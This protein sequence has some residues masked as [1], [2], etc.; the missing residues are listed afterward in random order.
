MKEISKS[1][2][3]RLT[4]QMEACPFCDSKNGDIMLI[5]FHHM[6]ACCLDCDARGP[7]GSSVKE[8]VKLWNRRNK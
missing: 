4:S 3:K 7:V 2:H 5:H 6:V 8:A 1:E